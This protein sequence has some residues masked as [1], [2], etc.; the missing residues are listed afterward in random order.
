MIPRYWQTF[1]V[2]K[3][4][5]LNSRPSRKLS[6][7]DDAP[8]SFNTDQLLLRSTMKKYGLTIK[9]TAGIL[10]ISPTTLNQYLTIP[11]NIHYVGM[12][13]TYPALLDSYCRAHKKQV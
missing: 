12:P 11:S 4:I 9:E 6:G 5:T 13:S 1:P 2:G 7:I 3:D 10:S 8:E